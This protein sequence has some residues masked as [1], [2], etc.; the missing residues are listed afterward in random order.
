ML[1]T[2]PYILFFKYVIPSVLGLLAIS[3]A[4]IID[5]YFIGNYVG[6]VGLASINISYPITT[7]LFGL[8]LIFQ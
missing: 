4:S 6:A 2:K 3:S 5:G 8:A 1:Q 7:I